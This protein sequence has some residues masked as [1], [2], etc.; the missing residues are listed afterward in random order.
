MKIRSNDLVWLDAHAEVAVV[1]EQSIDVYCLQ[2][3]GRAHG[4]GRA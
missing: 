2:T 4:N 3:W 1:K